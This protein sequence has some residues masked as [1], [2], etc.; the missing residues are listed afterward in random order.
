MLFVKSKCE[1][2]V[3][4]NSGTH[5]MSLKCFLSDASKQFGTIDLLLILERVTKSEKLRTLKPQHWPFRKK[6]LLKL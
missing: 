1:Q 6:K 2:F 5:K 4:A 3:C